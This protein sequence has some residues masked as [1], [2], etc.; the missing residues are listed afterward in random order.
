MF[1]LK[2]VTSLWPPASPDPAPPCSP[3]NSPT[4]SPPVSPSRVRC[5]GPVYIP[6]QDHQYALSDC[7]IPTSPS[8]NDPSLGMTGELWPSASQQRH[9]PS[10]Q[11]RRAPSPPGNHQRPPQRRHAPSPPRPSPR[12]SSRAPYQSPRQFSNRFPRGRGRGRNL[13]EQF[14]ASLPRPIATPALVPPV[15]DRSPSPDILLEV[16]S[17]TRH[18]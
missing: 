15:R 12:T 4:A 11:R 14:M 13:F 2:P 7:S 1:Q 17:H 18:P 6:L 5:N 16:Y 3:V 9:R 8:L 10:R